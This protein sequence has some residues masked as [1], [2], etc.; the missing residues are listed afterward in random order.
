MWRL[1][2]SR[3]IPCSPPM[4]LIRA[5]YSS[6]SAAPKPSLIVICAIRAGAPTALD[7][8]EHDG[9]WHD[10]GSLAG[11]PVW[12]AHPTSRTSRLDAAVVRLGFRCYA[13]SDSRVVGCLCGVPTGLRKFSKS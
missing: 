3:T 4:G 2:R 8:V 9:S 12:W 13:A 11:E 10:A 1:R 6:C 7:G 5:S